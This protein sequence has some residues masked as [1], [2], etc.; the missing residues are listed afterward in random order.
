MSTRGYVVSNWLPSIPEEQETG[1]CPGFQY[2]G[3]IRQPLSYPVSPLDPIVCQDAGVMNQDQPLAVGE[4][5]IYLKHCRSSWRVNVLLIG[6]PSPV[7]NGYFFGQLFSRGLISLQS[8]RPLLSA[9][10]SRVKVR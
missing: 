8:V 5:R 7:S 4:Q 10:A 9:F 1:H 2:R 3:R 6:F